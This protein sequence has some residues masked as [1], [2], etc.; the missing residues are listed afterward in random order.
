MAR[1]LS[2]ENL[3]QIANG[4]SMMYY[5]QQGCCDTAL[6]PI[7]PETL[8]KD[9]LGLRV[10][11]LPLCSDGS[12]LG[13]STFDD[14][15]IQIA[16]DDGTFRIEQLTA[17]DIAIDQALVE[18]SNYG[19]RNFTIMHE[20]AHHILCR[21]F[22]REYGPLCHRKSHIFYR[23]SGKAHD[24]IEWQ[25]DTLAASLLMPEKL[26]RQSM[27][28]FCLGERLEMLNRVFRPN[29]YAAFCTMAEYIGVSKQALEI[30]MK[31]LNLLGRSYLS[32]PY[33]L[34]D[35]IMEDT[36]ELSDTAPRNQ[37]QAYKC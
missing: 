28:N 8:A 22:P 1:Y 7:C 2:R 12:I 6:L 26:I 25:A 5:A 9:V 17:R 21:M 30:R 23:K 13:L 32:N 14:V 33:A 19:R 16:L 24:W 36:D 35:V 11:S 34:V 10:Q 20:I 27:K 37:T 18:S 31:Q 4:Y 15:E 29:S 3:E